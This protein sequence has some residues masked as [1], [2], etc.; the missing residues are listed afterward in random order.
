MLVTAFVM[1]RKGGECSIRFVLKRVLLNLDIRQQYLNGL[2]LLTALRR[3]CCCGSQ[4]DN[5]DIK[6][7][8]WCCTTIHLVDR[9]GSS[10]LHSPVSGLTAS[11]DEVWVVSYPLL[12]LVKQQCLLMSLFSLCTQPELYIYIQKSNRNSSTTLYCC[13]S[14]GC[15]YAIHIAVRDAAIHR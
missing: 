4:P 10:V 6:A 1:G 5:S 8:C 2:T 12:F 7:N 3:S 13:S 15:R 9:E 11:A 14:W